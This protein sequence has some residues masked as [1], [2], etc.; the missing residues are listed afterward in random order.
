MTPPAI[1][2][3]FNIVEI[4]SIKLLLIGGLVF[5]ITISYSATS[6]AS[7]YRNCARIVQNYIH[8]SRKAARRHCHSPLHSVDKRDLFRQCENLGSRKFQQ[9]YLFMIHTDPKIC[10]N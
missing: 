10:P 3:Y 6:I 1:R 8:A 5:T 4:N 9:V 2:I 7:E